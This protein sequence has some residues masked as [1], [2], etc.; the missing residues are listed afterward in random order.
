M[1]LCFH[2]KVLRVDVLLIKL[3]L[4]LSN[5][6]I[7]F[8]NISISDIMSWLTGKFTH[9]HMFCHVASVEAF[10]TKATCM[11]SRHVHTTFYDIALNARCG[12]TTSANKRHCLLL[13]V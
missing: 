1:A 9:I 10:G 5:S 6:T 13:S 12:Y 11:S 8:L 7:L 4:R 2:T 3:C